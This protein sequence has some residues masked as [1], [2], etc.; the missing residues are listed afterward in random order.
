MSATRSGERMLGRRGSGRRAYAEATGA[1]DARGGSDGC[2]GHGRPS[3]GTDSSLGDHSEFSPRPP[4]PPSVSRAAPCRQPRKLGLPRVG[5]CRASPPGGT[6][7]GHRSGGFE[8]GRHSSA[9]RARTRSRPPGRSQCCRASW[10]QRSA[11]SSLAATR[12]RRE[13]AQSR[14]N[15]PSRG[16]ARACNV[17]RMVGGGGSG[18]PNGIQTGTLPAGVGAV[19]WERRTSPAD[20][21]RRAALRPRVATLV[22]AAPAATARA[23]RPP[24]D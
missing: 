16:R 6:P 3:G 14:R 19:R 4:P 20:E 24:F 2:C 8:Q 18:V 12:S 5:C 17:L 23:S 15:R 21:C 22:A 7:K 13:P 9:P 11:A 1:R 10:R